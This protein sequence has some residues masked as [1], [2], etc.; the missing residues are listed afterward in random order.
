[1]LLL[2]MMM[3]M[4]KGCCRRTEEAAIFFS[5]DQDTDADDY[6]QDTD[7]DDDANDERM[8]QENRGGSGYKCRLAGSRPSSGITCKMKTMNE[9]TKYWIIS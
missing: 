3:P 7:A 1:M 2:M 5:T 8:L 9:Q 4:M 6:D